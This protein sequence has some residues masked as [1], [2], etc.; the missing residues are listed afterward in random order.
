MIFNKIV[1][2]DDTGIRAWAKEELQEFARSEVELHSTH[3]RNEEETLERIGDAECVLVSWNTALTAKILEQAPNIRYVGM[4]C[5]LFDEAS[6]NVHIPTA[7]KKG[8]TVKGIF[9]YGDEGMIEFILSELIHLMKGL[10]GLQWK[11]EPVELS[12]RKLGIIGM[13]TTG[14]MLMR[15]AQAFGMDILYYSRSRKTSLEQESATY[16][17]LPQ[18][19][20]ESEIISLHLPRNT[21]LLGQKEFEQLGNGKILVNTSLGLTFD[22]DS[23]L[24]WMEHPS[25]YAIFDSVGLGTHSEELSQ[26]P[27]II[28]HPLVSGWTLEAK[29]RLSRKVLDNIKRYQELL[30]LQSDL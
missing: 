19:L 29:D 3:P 7:R 24:N 27:R 26:H 2:V 8:I 12:Q 14:A 5:S 17:P 23:F 28:C 30:H 16:F 18:L 11:E 20:E 25:N 13:G 22:K 9:H 6:S 15:R 21:Q 1:A 10:G 4:C